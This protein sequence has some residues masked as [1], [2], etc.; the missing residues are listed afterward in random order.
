MNPQGTEYTEKSSTTW[1]DTDILKNP[2]E[3]GDYIK[4]E[5]NRLIKE[6]KEQF[7]ASRRGIENQFKAETT[8]E[9]VLFGTTPE[10][11]PNQYK[12]QYSGEAFGGLFQDCIACDVRFPDP[13]VPLGQLYGILANDMLSRYAAMLSGFR[14]LLTNNDINRDICNLL[15]FMNFQCLPDLYGLLSVLS[16]MALKLKDSVILNP[17]TAL[18]SL[19]S[20]IFAPILS[21]ISG[22]LDQ[23]INMILRPIDCVIDSLTDRLAQLDPSNAVRNAANNMVAGLNAEKRSIES[24]IRSLS[25]RRDYLQE[26]NKDGSYKNSPNSY[27]VNFLESDP[28]NNAFFSEANSSKILTRDQEL[29]NINQEIT[30]LLTRYTEISQE[31]EVYAKGQS[32]QIESIQYGSRQVAG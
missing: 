3:V 5:N 15:N 4:D 14:N 27:E 25:E 29:Q 30:K 8:S 20:P 6:T 9:Q 19:I 17:A 7:K 23:Y 31:I 22:L 11:A 10:I 18:L 26:R 12:K 13:T 28:S 21:G 16:M 1:E 2:G 24:K 32:F